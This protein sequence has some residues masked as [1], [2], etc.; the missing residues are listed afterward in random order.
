MIDPTPTQMTSSHTWTSTTSALG[1]SQS[2]GAQSHKPM[3]LHIARL[4]PEVVIAI[5]FGMVMFLIAL[6]SLWQTH[7]TQ[8]RRS[9]GT[10][11]AIIAVIYHVRDTINRYHHWSG[12]PPGSM[13]MYTFWNTHIQN[14]LCRGTF[15]YAGPC[16]YLADPKQRL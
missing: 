13:G 9:P 8:Q 11:V 3:A 5:A 12:P 15:L 7:R 16:W 4:S 14:L 2:L 6:Y 1:P 10:N